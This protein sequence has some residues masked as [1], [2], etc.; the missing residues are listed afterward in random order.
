VKVDATAMPPGLSPPELA[1]LAARLR[2]A[3][4]F[5]D[6]VYCESDLD[7]IWSTSDMLA[8]Q[9]RRR[10]AEP[11]ELAPL[12]ELQRL[13]HEAHD[14]AAE[15]KNELAAT[16]LDEAAMLLRWSASRD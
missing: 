3:S 6:K 13:V 5:K 9:L 14:L 12:L 1:Q 16:V 2:A 8:A 15:D 10:A 7:A 11:P 4:S